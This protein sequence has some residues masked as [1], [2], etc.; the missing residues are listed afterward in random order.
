M[1]LAV[2][3]SGDVHTAKWVNSF[4]GAGHEVHLI[5]Q[6]PVWEEI[7]AR[8]HLLPFRR[9]WGGVLNAPSLRALLEGIRPDLLHVHGASLDGLLGRLSGFHPAL[10]SVLGGDVFVF[11]ARSPLHRR[12]FR[13]NLDFYDALGSTSQAMADKLREIHPGA[14]PVRVTPFGVDSSAFRPVPGLRERGLVTIGAV[15]SLHPNYGL[16]TLLRAFALAR[17]R[18]RAFLASSGLGLRL[19]IFGRGPQLRELQGLASSLGIAGDVEF[20]G[21]VLNR[22]VPEKLNAMDVFANLSRSESFGVSVVEASACGLP[23]VASSAGG[24]PEVVRHAE[25]GFLVEPGNPESA[26]EALS[27]LVC[28]G[29]LRA[30]LGVAGREFVR[31]RFEWK[32][33][34]R[35]M[36][37]LCAHAASK[38]RRR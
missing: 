34:V 26:A 31:S 14:G 21:F 32:D 25:T 12:L 33:C 18:A 24:L 20:A 16:D 27:R 7:R 23:V 35:T 4:A 37:A 13:G 6:E 9:P 17:E 22:A 19:R 1:R 30:R 5:V 29:D 2:L 36:E 38:G 11:P 15:K 8:V 3:A 10:L 28:D